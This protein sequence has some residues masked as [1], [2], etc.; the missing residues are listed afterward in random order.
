MRIDQ[1]NL[2]VCIKTSSETTKIDTQILLKKYSIH[3]ERKKI[4]KLLKAVFKRDTRHNHS[5]TTT[6]PLRLN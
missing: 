1:N 6:I 4:N 5:L 3:A 2:V